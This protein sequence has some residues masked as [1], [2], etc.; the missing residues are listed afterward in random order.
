MKRRPA[1]LTMIEPGRL[2][3]ARQNHG[4]LGSGIVGPHQASSIRSVV[5]AGRDAGEEPAA[6]VE[7]PSRSS[8][9]SEVGLGQVLLAQLGVALEAAAAEDHAAAG[10]DLVARA[11]VLDATPTTRPS[12][13]SRSVSSVS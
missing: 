8:S 3:S 4:P 7:L 5:G 6:G 11:V 2:R 12:S 10:A 9:R 1:W 13:M